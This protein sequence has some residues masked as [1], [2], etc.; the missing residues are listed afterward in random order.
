MCNS[1][2]LLHDS[3]SGLNMHRNSIMVL[4]SLRTL[5]CKLCMS[6]DNLHQHALC[7]LVRCTRRLSRDVNENQSCTV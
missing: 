4:P 6:A 2:R 7:C 3:D 1:Y 5:E